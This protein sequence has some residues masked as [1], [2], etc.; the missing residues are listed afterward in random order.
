MANNLSTEKKTQIISMLAED[1]SIRAIE[2][3]TGVHRDTVMR[4]GVRV[5]EACAKIHDEKMR[6]LSCRSIPGA[7]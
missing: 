4:L 7:A 3:I 1:S 5:G 2:R 6:G